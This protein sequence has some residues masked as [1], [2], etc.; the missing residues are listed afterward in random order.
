MGRNGQREFNIQR[1]ESNV[2]FKR[3]PLA[4]AHGYAPLVRAMPTPNHVGIALPRTA[5]V[6]LNFIR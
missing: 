5:G 4:I 1:S 6:P 2:T 3:T